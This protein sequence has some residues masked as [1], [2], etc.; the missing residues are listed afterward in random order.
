MFGPWSQ[1]TTVSLAATLYP[2]RKIKMRE[3]NIEALLQTMSPHLPLQGFDPETWLTFPFNVALTDGE[4][5]FAL[6]ERYSE[7]VVTGH[8]F[9]KVR[10]KKAASVAKTLLKEAFTG[11]YNIQTIRGLTPL[12]KLGA[13]W[14]SKHI[15]FKSYGEVD[16]KAGP[17]EL[18][19]LNKNEWLVHEQEWENL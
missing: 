12:E 11:P 10:G 14:L 18:F 8:Y 9:F 1:I 13:R 4:G 6:F 3:T 15:G 17:C 2:N 5:N 19:I 7:F 16:T